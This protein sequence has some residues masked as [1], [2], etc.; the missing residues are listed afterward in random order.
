MQAFPQG[1]DHIP[2]SVAHLRSLLKVFSYVSCLTIDP[3]KRA[4]NLVEP[5]T[6]HDVEAVTHQPAHTYL[7]GETYLLMSLVTVMSGVLPSIG[8]ASATSTG[9]GRASKAPTGWSTLQ[10]GGHSD[11]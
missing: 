11:M 4:P 7:A 10:T 9:P 2:D 3:C 5:R 1:I 6:D 8:V